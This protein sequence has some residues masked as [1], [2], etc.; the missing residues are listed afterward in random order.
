M[1]LWLF[2]AVI[3]T[4]LFFYI[5]WWIPVPLDEPACGGLDLFWWLG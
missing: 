3:L 4:P 1:G 5:P 2:G